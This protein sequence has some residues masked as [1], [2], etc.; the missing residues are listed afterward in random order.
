MA[1]TAGVG[2]NTSVFKICNLRTSYTARVDIEDHAKGGNG[3][4]Y[5]VRLKNREEVYVI[6]WDSWLK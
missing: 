6:V 3:K 2:E 1:D 4:L 5:Y